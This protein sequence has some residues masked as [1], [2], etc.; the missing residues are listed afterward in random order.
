MWFNYLINAQMTTLLLGIL[1][2][3]GPTWVYLAII[4][5]FGYYMIAVPLAAWL[6]LDSSLTAGPLYLIL[7]LSGSLLL[8][9]V[10][11]RGGGSLVIFSLPPAFEFALAVRS[12]WHLNHR[13]T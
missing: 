11:V 5:F 7:G 10:L 12:L 8:G 3:H 1:L 4:S 2:L 13:P 6:L 9:F